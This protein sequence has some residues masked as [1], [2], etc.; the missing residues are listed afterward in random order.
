MTAERQTSFTDE[1]GAELLATSRRKEIR[2]AVTCAGYP[3]RLAPVQAE[4]L[5]HRLLA[6]AKEAG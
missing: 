1:T 3:V 5:A 6:W 4:H 2:I